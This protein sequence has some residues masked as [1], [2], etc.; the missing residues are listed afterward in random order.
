[1]PLW[2]PLDLLL[3]QLRYFPLLLSG[4]SL[5]LLPYFP[6]PLWLR[7]D[8]RLQLLQLLRYFPSPLSGRLLRLLQ[9]FLWLRLGL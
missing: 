3:R 1:M 9:L 2:L 6:L 8:L 4:Q 5:R 7:R